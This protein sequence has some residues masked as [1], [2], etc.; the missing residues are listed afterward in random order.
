MAGVETPSHELRILSLVL[1]VLEK[2]K[3]R[4]Q[5]LQKLSA[6]LEVSGQP[7]SLRIHKLER[8]MEWLDSSDHLLVRV[9][10]PVLLW[11]EQCA[12]AIE[13]WRRQNGSSIGRWLTAVGD[14][15]ALSSFASLAFERP[16][17]AIPVLVDD[18]TI[19]E[20]TAVQHPLLSAA[21]CIPNDVSIGGEL[22]LLIISGSNMS[23]KST[24]LRSVG[25][26]TVLAWA[27]APVAA[28]D[29]ERSRHYRWV[30]PCA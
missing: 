14:F 12:L 7:A 13:D 4:S 19:F 17:W 11:N 2:Q 28:A 20:S 15:E 30:L 16:Q 24:L 6:A 25:L 22:R 18:A 10:R 8:W 5:R 1:G 9:L 23:G 21:Q 29:F 27:G 26:N 3:F